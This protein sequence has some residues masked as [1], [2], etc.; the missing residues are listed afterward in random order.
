LQEEFL[1]NTKPISN[2]TEKNILSTG[3]ESNIVS[4][5]NF[6]SLAKQKQIYNPTIGKFGKIQSTP[7]QLS[8]TSKIQHGHYS[9]APK[10]SFTQAKPSA[11]QLVLN[12]QSL[13]PTQEVSN[14]QSLSLTQEV[15][16]RQSLSPTQEVSHRQSLSPTQEVSHRQSLDE[17]TSLDSNTPLDSESEKDHVIKQIVSDFKP[18]EK[19]EA[20]FDIKQCFSGVHTDT[21]FSEKIDEFDDDARTITSV[22]SINTVRNLKEKTES[23][24]NTMSLLLS[25]YNVILME[26]AKNEENFT[27]I[28][29]LLD[30]NTSFLNSQLVNLES[31]INSLADDTIVK[32]DR[33]CKFSK[34]CEENMLEMNITCPEFA[35]LQPFSINFCVHEMAEYPVS[36]RI[37][38]TGSSNPTGTTVLQCDLEPDGS[39]YHINGN[40]SHSFTGLECILTSYPFVKCQHLD[41]NDITAICFAVTCK[42]DNAVKICEVVQNRPQKIIW[43]SNN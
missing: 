27:Q 34:T 10:I 35:T 40:V 24:S 7:K 15:S 37:Y 12:R 9:K 19:L 26:N 32:I 3:A 43:C 1:P 36:I 31:C 41:G 14:R 33:E 4:A 25:Q 21:I 6:G 13:S 17:Y 23:I 42:V 28:Q 39:C 18:N 2:D 38:C 8:S 16:N 5:K 11:N 20:L 22:S 29:S 30:K